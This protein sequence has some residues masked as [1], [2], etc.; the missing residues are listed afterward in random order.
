[1]NRIEPSPETR[2]LLWIPRADIPATQ[3][4]IRDL[5]ATATVLPMVKT[6]LD[7]LLVELDLG[8]VR[9][10]VWP[11]VLRNAR[12]ASNISKDLLPLLVTRHELAALATVPR[13]PEAIAVGIAAHRDARVPRSTQH[14]V[15]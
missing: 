4:A 12:V 10:D 9:E 11:E 15:S 8:R 14:T 7:D 5:Y 13:L 1:M 3:R 2:S 6:V